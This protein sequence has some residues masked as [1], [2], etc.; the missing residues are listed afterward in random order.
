MFIPS[1]YAVHM[2]AGGGLPAYNSSN[3]PAEEPNDRLAPSKVQ[4]RTSF[5]N[6]AHTDVKEK[7]DNQLQYNA[8]WFRW[9]VPGL[10][11]VDPS[12]V[13]RTA[14]EPFAACHK[15]SIS[16]YRVAG[17]FVFRDTQVAT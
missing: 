7:R 13:G 16:P 1:N 8:C 10:Q 4:S 2:S 12:V 9:H 3:K 15:Y 17:S 6:T 5:V 14:C 11:G